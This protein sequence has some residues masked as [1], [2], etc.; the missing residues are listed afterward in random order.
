MRQY[1]ELERSILL[2]GVNT[3]DRTGTG[4]KT[5]PGFFYSCP[6]NKLDNGIIEKFPL[7]TTKF[8]SLQS[9]FEELIWKLRGDTNIKYLVERNN[10]IWTEWPFKAYLLATNQ[11]SVIDN[12]WADEKKNNFS[13]EW[14]IKKKEFEKQII[15]NEEFNQKWGN[16]GKTY[17]YNFRRYGELKVKDLEYSA[18]EALLLAGMT[19]ETIVRKGKDQLIEAIELIQNNPE[20]RRIIITLWDPQT[21]DINNTLLPPCP[22]FYQFF[23][24]DEGYLHMNMYQRSCDTFLGVPYNTAQDALLL[25][26]ISHITGKKPG[27]FN[28]MFGDAHIYLNHIH[29]VETQLQRVPFELPKIKISDSIKTLDDILNSSY[30]DA[31][32]LIDYN[33]YDSIKGAVSI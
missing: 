6:L 30:K 23:A 33:H 8:V 2:G 4:T 10:H 20:S 14:K 32:E 3:S 27:K 29:Q 7:L 5:L 12:M 15:S 26:L 16:L 28:H 13:D 19:E 9:V 31:I 22:T 18:K 17:G 11:K 24:N 25:C 1:Q 21:N